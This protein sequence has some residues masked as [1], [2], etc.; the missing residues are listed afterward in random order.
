MNA[1]KLFSTDL[2][3]PQERINHWTRFFYEFICTNGLQRTH[4]QSLKLLQ[5]INSKQPNFQAR[6]EYVNIGDLR[7]CKI[8]ANQQHFRRDSKP[9]MEPASPTPY[10]LIIVQ[11]YGKSEFLHNGKTS[12]LSAGQWAIYDTR[13]P[14]A[15][16]NNGEVEQFLLLIPENEIGVRKS[17]N[18]SLIANAFSANEGIGLIAAQFLQ[19]VFWES[20]ACSERA[21][22]AIAL[23]TARLF[24][25]AVS[26][27]EDTQPLLSKKASL[28]TQIISF[29]ENN[30][31]DPDLSIDIMANAFNCSKRNLHKV[32][33]DNGHTIHAYILRRRLE[34]CRDEIVDLSSGTSC[35][36]T[37]I[38]YKW[39]F[40]NPSHFSKSF[41]NEYG[42]SP[43]EYRLGYGNMS[44]PID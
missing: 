18:S 33:S 3:Q 25:E 5:G 29:I 4:W 8:N 32:F 16:R 15:T 21:A 34:C 31:S 41:K 17:G 12:T 35:Y 27:K 44:P 13:G 14:F 38:A 28:R 2:I 24:R 26:E 30:L 40:N 9:T 42:L 10:Q 7:I 1:H 23:S 6:A 22:Q 43:R 37:E 36:I 19:S 20:T 11:T 39:G